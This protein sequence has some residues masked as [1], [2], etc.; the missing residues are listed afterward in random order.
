MQDEYLGHRSEGAE[1]PLLS[2]LQNTAALARCHAEAFGA[3]DLGHALGL[4]HDAGKYAKKFQRR[5]RGE[6]IRVDHAT[7]GG[8]LLHGLLRG[9]YRTVGAY[10]AMGHHTGLPDGGTSTDGEKLPTLSRK[11]NP[12][13]HIEP[14]DAYKTE[15]SIP[16]P[17]N[18]TTP[19]DSPFAASFFT[20]MLFSALV[21]ADFIDTERFFAE[22]TPERG[23]MAEISTLYDKLLAAIHDFL[24][25]GGALSTL[26]RYRH[27]L[28][29]NCLDK[30][31][32][33]PGLFTLTAP[34]GSGKTI[35]SLSFALKH[36]TENGLRRVIYVVPYNTIIEQNARVFEEIL[37][38]EHVLQHHSGVTYDEDVDG[39]SPQAAREHRRKRLAA[40]NWDYPVVVTSNVQF[41]ES[42]F[43]AKP[44]RCR[45]LHNIARSVIIFDEAQ[46]LPLPY[47][48]PCIQAIRELVAAY[49]CTA[50][51]ATAT[52]S[53][54]DAYFARLKMGI[55]EINADAKAMVD[56][57]RRVTLRRLDDPLTDAELS[58]LLLQGEQAL[59]IVNTRR[60]AQVLF[61]LL[62]AES[63]AGIFHL[64]TTMYPAHRARVLKHIRECLKSGQRCLVISTSLVEAGVDVDFPAVYRAEAGLDSVIQAAGRCN[65][66][67]RLRAEEAV[68]T[69][70]RAAEHGA[71][72]SAEQSAGVFREVAR[73]FEDLGSPEAVYA[74]FQRLFYARGDAALDHKQVVKALSDGHMMFPFQQVAKDFHLIEETQQ[75]VYLL[76]EAPELEERLRRGERTRALFRALTPYA[77]SL[78]ANDLNQQRRMG[79][80]TDLDEA[81]R[82]YAPTSYDEALGIP[83]DPQGGQGFFA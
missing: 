2:H 45:K 79:L 16:I 50:V 76:A 28:L 4:A 47:L 19:I 25:P 80:V 61:K 30:A 23:G 64:S 58:A 57:L 35:A 15:L 34:T 13:Y 7:A 21:D 27:Q 26:N 82:L 68:V 44:S 41:F 59:C 6:N 22:S 43:A 8:R 49:G 67:G 55:T 3:G 62:R 10:C 53:A 69:I 36:A 60:H 73:T 78:Y 29:T 48:L 66:E 20:R 52:Q 9:A 81:V 63:P 83:L 32:H 37:G 17:A 72:R 31:V 70:F 11:L 75:T 71:S 46:M 18:P 54:L 65:R 56:A 14:F 77:V 5:I 39:L 33:A 74:Y 40:E 24:H 51:L 12:K 42:L 1:Q 38:A